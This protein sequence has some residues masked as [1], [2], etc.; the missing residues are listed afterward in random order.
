MEMGDDEL[1]DNGIT[2]EMDG[3]T[4]ESRVIQHG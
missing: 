3:V 4:V 2:V 1:D